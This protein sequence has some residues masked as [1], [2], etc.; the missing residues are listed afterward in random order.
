MRSSSKAL[1]V[2]A[3][4]AASVA[5]GATA[6]A[7]APLA[8]AATQAT[9]PMCATAQLT[10]SLGGSDAGAGQI[11]QDVV[12]TNHSSTTCHLTGYPGVSVLDS[13]GKEIGAPATHDPRPYGA[14]V[15]A[16]GASA[17]TT[18]HTGNRM[19]NNPGECRPVSSSVRVYPPGNRASLVIPAK[20]TICDI[21]TVIPLTATGTGTPSAAPSSASSATPSAAPTSQVSAVPSGAPATGEAPT[22]SGGGSAGALAAGAGALLVVG[23]TGVAVVR[24]RRSRARG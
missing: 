24:S 20:L 5:L 6:L 21:F 19:T 14:V 18:I 9:T 12:L 22:S 7:F 10:G 15:L 23:G 4:G 3:T 17:S 2:A 8:G 11:Y 13:H 1:R 16:P